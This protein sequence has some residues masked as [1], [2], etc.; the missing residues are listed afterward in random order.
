MTIVKGRVQLY[1]VN[2][3]DGLAS[4][5]ISLNRSVKDIRHPDCK[6]KQYLRQ[7]PSVTVILP[8][9]NEVSNK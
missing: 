6:K 2:G 8:F 9:H 5:Q 4:D 1:R 3:F 7:L